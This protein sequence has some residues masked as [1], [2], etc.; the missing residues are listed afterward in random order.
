MFSKHSSYYFK[1]DDCNQLDNSSFL[2]QIGGSFCDTSIDLVTNEVTIDELRFIEI[3]VA[4]VG[5]SF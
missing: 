2:D 1:V 4:G 3:H 5:V